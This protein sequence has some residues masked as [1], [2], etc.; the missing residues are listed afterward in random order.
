[1]SDGH[2]F[3]NK[4]NNENIDVFIVKS[5]ILNALKTALPEL[6]GNLLDVGCGRMPYKDYI[7][8]TSLVDFYT[9]LDIKDAKV[10]DTEISP[11]FLWDGVTMPFEDCCY[12]CVIATEVFEHCPEPEIIMKE[13]YRVLK[14]DGILF[15]TVPFL[16][17][18]H[19]IPNDQYRYTPYAIK[20]HLNSS[21]FKTIALYPT[22]G[23]HAALAQMLGLWVKRSGLSTT[24][25]KMISV[26]VKPIMKF[27][28]KKDNPKLVSFK[29]QQMITGI[30]GI[31]RK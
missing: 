13:I 8:E 11:D 4:L 28:L 19:E 15:F 6:M 17:P 10:Y 1:M 30:Y 7:L 18:L 16:W 27:L 3:P 9:G 2:F 29:E 24:K 23:W 22:G 20:R 21:G 25:Q 5:S 31:I 26:F 14:P 12:D